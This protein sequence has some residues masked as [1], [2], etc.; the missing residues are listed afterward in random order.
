[1][2]KYFQLGN[3]AR[4]SAVFKKETAIFAIAIVCIMATVGCKAKMVATVYTSDIRLAVEGDTSMTATLD[5]ALDVST[6]SNC[7]EHS[8]DIEEALRIRYSE[9]EF[10]GCEDAGFDTFANFR[11]QAPIV[12]VDSELS[13]DTT[14]PVYVGVVEQDSGV[15]IGFVVVGKRLENLKESL[16]DSLTM[17]GDLEGQFHASISNDERN[18][19]KVRV[20]GAFANGSPVVLEEWYELKRRGIID[21]MLSDVANS[22]LQMPGNNTAPIAHIEYP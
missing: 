9:V 3:S 1:M 16:P 8:P 17:Y 21:I 12:V 19:V 10:V 18:S 5:I 7:K 20:G 2:T 15:S 14:A 11:V 4:N 13:S 6:E 22:W